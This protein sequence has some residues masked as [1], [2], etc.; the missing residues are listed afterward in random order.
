MQCKK[1]LHA[2]SWNRCTQADFCA[3]DGHEAV[4]SN[5]ELSLFIDPSFSTDRK[6]NSSLLDGIDSN[7]VPASNVFSKT[8][9][10]NSPVFPRSVALSMGKKSASRP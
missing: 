7:S 8:A 2:I 10:V 5:P 4:D 3:C 6:L 1:L 9:S